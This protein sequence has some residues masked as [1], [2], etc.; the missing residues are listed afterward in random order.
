MI[1]IAK[2]IIDKLS[3]GG[4][5]NSTEFEIVY[6]NLTG[7]KYKYKDCATCFKT[8]VQELKQAVEKKS[9]MEQAVIA[10]SEVKEVEVEKLEEPTPTNTKKTKK[11]KDEEI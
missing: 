10:E 2:A 3:K 1:E 8:A 4:R 11:K 7:K 9:Q 6:N 5:I